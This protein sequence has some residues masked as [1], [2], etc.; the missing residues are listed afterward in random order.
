MSVELIPAELGF[1]RPFTRE[2]VQSL[3]IRNTQID[4]VAFKVKT[5][6][7]K[8]Y[9]VRPNSGRIEAGKEVEVQV[10][11]QAMK[12][13]PPA[14]FKCKD[15][16]LVQSV[17]ITSDKEHGTVAEIWADVDKNDKHSIQEKKIR[18]VFLQP[19][20]ASSPISETQENSFDQGRSSP[21]PYTS[22]SPPHENSTSQPTIPVN[23]VSKPET[24]AEHYSSGG[25]GGN[26]V[27]VFG[28]PNQGQSGDIVS[29][30]AEARATISK[31]EDQLKEQ[32]VRQRKSEAVTSYSKGGAGNGNAAM[33]VSQAPEGIPVQICAALCLVA[34]FIAWFFF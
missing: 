1:Q 5:T 23:Q 33:T 24:S 25:A 28:T 9:C 11:L 22:P 17:V 20:E 4:P 19:G 7:P 30:L 14:D 6:A 32:V 18:V 2:V 21:P 27:A 26:A 12:Q 10:L 3:R 31:L 8:Q 34:F 15:K 13:D 16:F 29:Q